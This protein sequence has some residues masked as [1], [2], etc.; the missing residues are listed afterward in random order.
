MIETIQLTTMIP[1]GA[2]LGFLLIFAL[3]AV[4][5]D[6]EHENVDSDFFDSLNQSFRDVLRALSRRTNVEEIDEPEDDWDEW[7][8]EISNG[9]E[10]E[11]EDDSLY[12][13]SEDSPDEDSP[14]SSQ[15]HSSGNYLGPFFKNRGGKKDDA[16]DDE[17]QEGD[18]FDD[19]DGEAEFYDDDNIPDAKK[20][21]TLRERVRAGEESARSDLI[22]LILRY[23][24]TLRWSDRE[25]ALALFDEAQRNL[26]ES[27]YIFGNEYD[28]LSCEIVLLRS[29][30]YLRNRKKAPFDVVG[31]AL[32]R[33]RAWYAKEKSAQAREN[34]SRTWLMHGQ[35]LIF[36]GAGGVALTS[37]Q[38]AEE[39]ATESD[40]IFNSDDRDARFLIPLKTWKADAYRTVGD[41]KEAVAH[42]REALSI[43]DVAKRTDLIQIQKANILCQLA[44]TL[45][46]MGRLDEVKDVLEQA[47]SVQERLYL[48]N[49]DRFYIP[50][51]NIQ[52][53]QAEVY[54]SEQNFQV[55]SAILDRSIEI[56]R[57][58]LNNELPLKKRVAS[59]FLLAGAL[60]V[61]AGL[62]LI[63]KRVNAASRDLQALFQAV[64][65]ALEKD[66]NHSPSSVFVSA[67]AL[68]HDI[69]V[70]A[71]SWD[72]VKELDSVFEEIRSKLTDSERLTLDADYCDALLHI[73]VLLARANRMN[74]AKEATEKALAVSLELAKLDSD[75]KDRARLRLCQARIY[76]QRAAFNFLFKRNFRLIYE[77]FQKLYEA[78]NS[79]LLDKDVL[80]NDKLLFYNFYWRFAIL[81]W[82]FGKKQEAKQTLARSVRFLTSDLAS[83]EWKYW[84]FLE[85]DIRVS[86]FFARDS[87]DSRSYLRLV[88]FW[89][90]YLQHL[91]RSF[92]SQEWGNDSSSLSSSDQAYL[93]RKN[94][95][96]RIYLVRERVHFLE[97][98][99]VLGEDEIVFLPE[100]TSFLTSS[101]HVNPQSL[102]GKRAQFFTQK[103]AENVVERSFF[104][105]LC[106][107]SNAYRKLIGTGAYSYCSSWTSIN[108]TLVEFYWKHGEYQLAY[109]EAYSSFKTTMFC[110]R[111]Y[112]PDSV[113]EI[114]SSLDNAR[115]FL[116]TI[117]VSTTDTAESEPESEEE[118][119]GQDEKSNALWTCAFFLGVLSF[120]TCCCL[121]L[122]KP[123]EPD[124][125]SDVSIE[126]IEETNEDEA[127]QWFK[128]DVSRA[129]KEG[130]EEREVEND[131]QPDLTVTLIEEKKVG[132]E[133]SVEEESVPF[134]VACSN[135][136]Y[137]KVMFLEA[138]LLNILRM[139]RKVSEHSPSFASTYLH[140]AGRYYDLLVTHGREKAARREILDSVSK[141]DET[142]KPD[143]YLVQCA[144]LLFY[145]EMA[146]AA[147][148]SETDGADEFEKELLERFDEKYSS[149]PT[150]IKKLL[151]AHAVIGRS[152]LRLAA[153]EDEDLKIKER[154]LLCASNIFVMVL[155]KNSEAR[156]E[157]FVGLA[158]AMCEFIEAS[159]VYVRLLFHR[160]E[161]FFDLL[162]APL[163]CEENNESIDDQ[164]SNL[165]E[166]AGFAWLTFSRASYYYGFVR[167]CYYEGR[168]LGVK[169]EQLSEFL[170][171]HDSEIQAAVFDATFK[172]LLFYKT[173]SI[174]EECEKICRTRSLATR[175]LLEFRDKF[176]DGEP[177]VDVIREIVG[178][179]LVVDLYH[180]ET[181]YFHERPSE[182]LNRRS[183][184]EI[185]R[186]Q[187]LLEGRPATL[188]LASTFKKWSFLSD[189]F[190]DRRVVE[191]ADKPFF[192][193]DWEM[194]HYLYFQARLYSIFARG[195]KRPVW[196]LRLLVDALVLHAKRYGGPLV[197]NGGFYY[198]CFVEY[199]VQRREWN[200]TISACKQFHLKIDDA[201]SRSLNE[202]E[203]L[204]FKFLNLKMKIAEGLARVERR[205]WGDLK[206]VA[207]SAD[208]IEEDFRWLFERHF[209]A[210]KPLLATAY[211]IRAH[212]ELARKDKE[213]ALKNA[214]RALELTRRAECRGAVHPLWNIRELVENF[215]SKHASN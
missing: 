117:S 71:R 129:V 103:L 96:L 12:E 63:E 85:S 187:K 83:R 160:F 140:C 70:A 143:N 137:N 153:L 156:D 66:E 92:L 138:W 77:D 193:E 172:S 198:Q 24:N 95:E 202:K 18:F 150:S 110:L 9:D 29:V 118:E 188:A 38:K 62:H 88:R 141:F 37:F 3:G 195:A 17:S 157:A 173:Y 109:Q 190:W 23:A 126:E 161:E 106:Q 94:D 136:P 79:E 81:Q 8:E 189:F 33:A 147:M 57:T 116:N 89:L 158:Q 65:Q 7:A 49:N 87:K 205:R 123:I 206:K 133:E 163:L 121:A 42:Y 165:L 32:S 131:P 90:S 145:H 135:L 184:E 125:R 201:F 36:S 208:E 215:I 64:A 200:A 30:F 176:S 101:N 146:N 27:T 177:S 171:S 211:Y 166:V 61:R 20:I 120:K 25:Q 128:A 14:E 182:E 185:T 154:R 139:G 59:L 4:T 175:R 82:K 119:N 149:A 39:L 10:E 204:E 84:E 180:Y 130:L 102:D 34:L 124:S 181:A 72:K 203:T 164:S 107:I 134:S 122:G 91:R 191:D 55:A 44:V 97:K 43:C 76:F 2:M 100:P 99:P 53:F 48:S 213:A 207:V 15:D 144:L 192:P 209:Y 152:F 186:I 210:A 179:E 132:E 6:N 113:K 127:D 78:A 155:E 93:L 86:L 21:E 169:A 151:L 5:Q 148:N 112:D 108:K 80:E 16:F 105:D 114:T 50:L 67:F 73:H 174:K 31:E 199:C 13:S 45:R 60:R 159:S 41:L 40:I 11:D 104:S 111:E 75:D 26:D 168:R 46:S 170:A 28:E 183:V 54:L 196:L 35:A 197:R 162:Y 19:E 167:N 22:R 51:V 74:D 56:L 98:H 212:L 178:S 58:N 52:R 1:L 214:R 47:H 68:V 194:E 69:A 115:A 142:V